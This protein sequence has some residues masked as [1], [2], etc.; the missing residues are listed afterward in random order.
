MN[1]LEVSQT[2]EGQEE[3]LKSGTERALG[4]EGTS[5]L[6]LVTF[7]VIF[8]PENLIQCQYL[9][10]GFAAYPITPKFSSS[11]KPHKKNIISQSF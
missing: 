6:D 9:N 2:D 4:S 5:L 8:G 10:T 3:K 7:K 1:D 11:L